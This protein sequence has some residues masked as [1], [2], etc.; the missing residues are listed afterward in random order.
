MK[1]L[2][3]L[4]LF[5]SSTQLFAQSELKKEFKNHITTLSSVEY[6]GR[7]PQTKGDTLAVKYIIDHLSKIEGVAL[8][9]DNGLQVVQ[10]SVSHY[11][12]IKPAKE[13]EKASYKVTKKE[14]ITFNVVARINAPK[15]KNR[16]KKSI[17]I[18]A[19][20]DH[21]GP[22]KN[23][24]GKEVMVVGADDNASGVATLIEYAREVARTRNN[25]KRDVIFVFFGAEEYGL[26]GSNYY[27]K[28]PLHNI[29]N[30]VAM[31]NFDM[32]GRMR[33]KGITV[34]GIASAVEAPVLLSSIKNPDKLDLIWE[35][36]PTGPTDYASFYKV[37]VPAFSFSTRQHPDYH[38]ERDTEEKINY[39]GMEMLFNYVKDLIH[40]LAYNDTKLTYVPKK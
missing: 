8:L 22:T 16:D 40:T 17:I 26:V 3:T 39:E 7:K 25:L 4:L 31:V 20:Y 10:D 12:R 23:K 2:I 37:G 38:T 28:N 21:V 24:D 6:M 34:R 13:G 30:S 29:K 1:K 14:M 35:F 36:N 32:T 18:G 27:A 11:E 19:H 9:G 33:N 5:L 15:D